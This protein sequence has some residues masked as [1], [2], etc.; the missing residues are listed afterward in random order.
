MKNA[1]LKTA[2]AFAVILLML[3]FLMPAQAVLESVLPADGVYPDGTHHRVDRLLPG[4]L[5][6]FGCLWLAN[7][8]TGILFLKCGLSA[9]RWSLFARP[10]SRRS[11]PS[12]G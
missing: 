10:L 4:T 12:L 7:R 3:V 2:F 6:V 9:E 8:I 5:V 1:L 11:G